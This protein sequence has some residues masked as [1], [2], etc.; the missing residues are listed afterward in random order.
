M[1]SIPFFHNLRIITYLT[2]LI[3][4]PLVI[5]IQILTGTTQKRDFSKISTILK[6]I[7]VA[8]L[9]SIV[10]ISTILQSNE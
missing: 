4:A 7:M 2:L 5:V 9:G 10:S 3:A 6:W 8:G 1:I